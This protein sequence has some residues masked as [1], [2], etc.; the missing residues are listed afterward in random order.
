M[1][2]RTKEGENFDFG[3]KTKMMYEYMCLK[4]H[5]LIHYGMK[6]KDYGRV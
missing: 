4:S 6:D 1:H 3:I 5:I 2:V